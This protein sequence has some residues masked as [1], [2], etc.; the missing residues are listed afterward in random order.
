MK[1]LNEL[2]AHIKKHNDAVIIIGPG[3]N[4]NKPKYDTD[5]FNAKYNRKNL[6]RNYD[7]LIKFYIDNIHSEI[8]TSKS[9]DLIKAINHSLLLDQNVNGSI[10]ASYLHGHV[11]IF[12]CQKCNNIYPLEGIELNT[13]E[14]TVSDCEC[15]G[16]KLRPSVL[17]S[18][19][20]YNQEI[21]D[22]FKEKL[23]DTHTLILIGMD[24]SE[25]PLLNLIA[26]YGDMR[27]QLNAEGNEDNE[28]CIVVIQSKEEEFNPNEITF[29]E[30][31]VKDDIENAL[32][33]LVG[34]L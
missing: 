13:E 2:T 29:C 34:A 11:N 9:Y 4:P 16:S 5:E 21:F 7:E 15:C 1:T 18:A 8:N 27:S 20:R 25:A 19:E 22:E 23:L 33:R 28:R 3:I 10:T 26:D 14:Y 12:K 31:L 32:T 6:K 24:Y 30:F 17:L